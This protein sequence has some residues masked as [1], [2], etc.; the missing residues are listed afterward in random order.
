MINLEFR[1]SSNIKIIEV[2]AGTPSSWYL[3]STL[4]FLFNIGDIMKNN[5]L[6]AMLFLL[7]Q[8]LSLIA[9]QSKEKQ[10][11]IIACK[12]CNIE[13][14]TILAQIGML[15]LYNKTTPNKYN[16]ESVELSLLK[17]ACL[18]II[19]N[20]QI[21]FKDIPLEQLGNL[22]ASCEII[23][24]QL[25]LALLDSLE[26][27]KDTTLKMKKNQEKEFAEKSASFVKQ[28]KELRPKIEK[29]LKDIEDTFKK[30]SK[31]QK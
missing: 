20:S 27:K 11:L 18:Q 29:G 2:R 4:L 14:V 23:K 13:L 12:V 6:L 3:F 5:I 19:A 24:P 15:E 26:N 25:L 30:A 16:L 21:S 9:D 7:G 1:K 31:Q 17:Q 22:L 8:D 28:L 10:E